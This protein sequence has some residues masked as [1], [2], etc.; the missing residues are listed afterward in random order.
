MDLPS[1]PLHSDPNRS[2]TNKSSIVFIHGLGG[3]RVK[4]WTWEGH[5]RVLFFDE[6]QQL[7]GMKVL[8]N[9]GFTLGR[10]DSFKV[11]RKAWRP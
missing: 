5:D 10:S 6:K 8:L 9:E 1:D 11:P 7:D 2:L 3:D 4:T